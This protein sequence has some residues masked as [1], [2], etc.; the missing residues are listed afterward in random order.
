MTENPDQLNVT[1]RRFLAGVGSLAAISNA[2]V[3]KA[4]T[5]TPEPSSPQDGAKYIVT[6][7]ISTDVIK[8]STPQM[9]NA[10][11]LPVNSKDVV[12]WNADAAGSYHL[13]VL[14]TP[15]TPFININSGK[16]VHAFHG[17]ESG[18][19][20]DAYI[21]PKAS[22]CYKYCVAV[23]NEKT[24]LSYADDPKILIGKGPD[25]GCAYSELMD[26][27][28]KL[29][30]AATQAFPSQRKKIQGIEH[31]LDEVIAKFKK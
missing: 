26:A 30:A 4:A 11:E 24:N 22:G 25:A 13:A 18:I 20:G 16:P 19:G 2:A 10:S 5:I 9:S 7:D 31:Q 6:L 21:D 14:F 23:W 15:R 17:N 28:E 3:L 1:R 29:K 12:V 27:S 8:Y